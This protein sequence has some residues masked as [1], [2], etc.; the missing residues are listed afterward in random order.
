MHMHT[1]IVISVS[2]CMCKDKARYICN[3]R[4]NYKFILKTDFNLL[5]DSLA[6]SF[7]YLLLHS[8]IMRAM[9]LPIY[10]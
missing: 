3:D 8:L 5:K 6:L 4:D 10:L 1:Y 9:F 7:S 2:I